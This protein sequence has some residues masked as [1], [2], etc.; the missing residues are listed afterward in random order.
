MR[1]IDADELMKKIDESP[2]CPSIL[3]V[4]H[5]IKEMPT[6]DVVPQEQHENILEKVILAW[7]DAELEK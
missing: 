7:V 6:L 3:D 1:P 5:F 4:I 2:Y